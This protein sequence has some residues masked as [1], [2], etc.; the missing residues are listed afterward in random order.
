MRRMAESVFLDAYAPAMAGD[1]TSAAAIL[2]ENEAA[3]PDLPW[4]WLAERFG[5]TAL[6]SRP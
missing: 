5:L 1:E 3:H 6:S 2:V 4:A